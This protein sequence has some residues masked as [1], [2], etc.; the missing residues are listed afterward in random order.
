M[1]PAFDV[2]NEVFLGVA[3]GLC[4]ALLFSFRNIIQRRKLAHYSAQQTLFYQVLVI[5]LVL[6]PFLQV[7]LAAVSTWQWGQLF[8][9]GVLFTALPHGLFMHG[10]RFLKAKTVSLIACLQIVH[11]SL[12]AALLLGEWPTPSVAVGGLIVFA[13]AVYETYFTQRDLDRRYVDSQ[14]GQ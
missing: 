8:V 9:L 5:V 13:A 14:R 6:L 7:P 3:W 12:F 10:L 1:V 2:D 4:S 11:A